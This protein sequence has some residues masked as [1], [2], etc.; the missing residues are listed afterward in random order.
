MNINPPDLFTFQGHVQR[1]EW[2]DREF[3]PVE[4]GAGHDASYFSYMIVVHS[5]ESPGRE[6]MEAQQVKT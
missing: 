1:E 4:H 5:P 3:T 2:G 6:E